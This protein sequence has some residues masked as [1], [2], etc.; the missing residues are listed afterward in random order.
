[1]GG[2]AKNSVVKRSNIP[3]GVGTGSRREYRINGSFQMI[4]KD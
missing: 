3:R 4:F 1:M 2:T